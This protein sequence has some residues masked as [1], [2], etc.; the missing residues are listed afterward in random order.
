MAFK[1]SGVRLPLAPPV[2][3]LNKI[4]YFKSR[5]VML[6]VVHLG[7]A[8]GKHAKAHVNISADRAFPLAI[9]TSGDQ[10]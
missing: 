6:H 3:L 10:P 8:L 5:I 1:R 7:E 2:N 9:N 4:Y